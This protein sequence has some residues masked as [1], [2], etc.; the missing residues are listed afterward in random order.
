MLFEL[1]PGVRTQTLD[2]EHIEVHHCASVVATSNNIIFLSNA[3]FFVRN[4]TI[5]EPGAE[6]LLTGLLL[7]A[8]ILASRNS[9]PL[10]Q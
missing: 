9:K 1:V 4:W 5:Y 10:T 7:M 8:D 6:H 2:W 3:R